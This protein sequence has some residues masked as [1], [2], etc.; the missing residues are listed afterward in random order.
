MTRFHPMS[1][2]RYILMSYVWARS[3]AVS[4]C[5]L[6]MITVCVTIALSTDIHSL[7]YSYTLSGD[8]LILLVSNRTTYNLRLSFHTYIHHSGGHAG[9]MHGNNRFIIAAAMQDSCMGTTGSSWR[10]PCRTHDAWEQQVH[11]GGGH[12]GLMYAWGQ[13][14]HNSS[15]KPILIEST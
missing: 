2:A 3:R 11:H 12:A 1:N 15:I 4:P 5:I 6:R 14:H 7:V 8:I 13:V 9:L 10:R